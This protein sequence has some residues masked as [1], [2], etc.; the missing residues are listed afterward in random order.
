MQP[1]IEALN[2]RV[3][4]CDGAMGTML[5][6]RGVFINRS[7][8][9]LN[10]SSPEMVGEVH[11]EYVRAGADIVDCV[12]NGYSHRAGN[13]ALERI[14]AALEVLYDVRTGVDLG[15]LTELCQLASEDPIMSP[16]RRRPGRA[17]ASR[18]SRP[19]PAAW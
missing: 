2:D 13:C 18:P 9:A 14:V 7:F 1:F 16:H 17:S 12:L 10:I 19:S 4:V 8:D 11:Q 15:R 5:Y 6:A 3:L